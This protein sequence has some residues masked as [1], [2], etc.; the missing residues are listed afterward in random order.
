MRSVARRTRRTCACAHP[1]QGAGGQGD[2]HRRNRAQAGRPD[3]QRAV[4]LERIRIL[5]Q[6]QHGT[7][8]NAAARNITARDGAGDRAGV[9]GDVVW[10]VGPEDL[11]RARDAVRRQPGRQRGDVAGQRLAPGAEQPGELDAV[12]VGV[13]PV[14]DDVQQLGA[15]HGHHGHA[16]LHEAPVHDRRGMAHS[17]PPE[18]GEQQRRLRREGRRDR[19]RPA[20]RGRPPQ[21]TGPHRAG[22]PR[23]ARR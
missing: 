17:L 21:L 10:V 23:R 16:I 12:Q 2:E 6:H 7:A 14:L 8:G 3:D 1:E 4:V 5:R 22:S 11:R 20:E 13:Q 15:G 9:P 18:E 19:H